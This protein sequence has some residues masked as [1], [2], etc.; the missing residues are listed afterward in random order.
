[1]DSPVMR[2]KFRVATVTA[3]QGCEILKMSAVSKDGA[4]GADGSD[5]DNTYAKYSP[6]GSFEVTIMNPALF[7]IFKPGDRYYMDFTL[8][9]A[10]P[11]PAQLG[12]STGAALSPN[13]AAP[14]VGT[15]NNTTAA[16][17]KE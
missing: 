9:P 4:Y 7:G 10:A 6:Q 1:M 8:A 12:A 5:E 3:M 11:A 2:A 17:A 15:Q 13:A 16:P 14:A